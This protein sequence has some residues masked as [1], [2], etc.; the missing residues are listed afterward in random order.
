MLPPKSR[1]SR[2]IRAGT[3][4]EIYVLGGEDS[5]AAAHSD[6]LRFSCACSTVTLA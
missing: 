2:P 5:R 3:R 1:A 6:I 4:F